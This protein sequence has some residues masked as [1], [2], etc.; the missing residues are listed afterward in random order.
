LATWAWA[1]NDGSLAT[2]QVTFTI[3]VMASR[4]PATLAAAAS[5]LSAAMRASA[6]A[7]SV[8]TPSPTLPTPWSLPSTSGSWPDV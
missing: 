7:S 5:A 6:A 1:V 4:P 8:V 3:R 2:K